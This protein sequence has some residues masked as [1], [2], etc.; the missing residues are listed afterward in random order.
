MLSQN[1]VDPS[2]FNTVAHTRNAVKGKQDVHGDLEMAHPCAM[3]LLTLQIGFVDCGT[4]QRDG[5]HNRWL[6]TVPRSITVSNAMSF[7]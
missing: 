4:F 5:F 3:A 1:A 2:R 6:R 7:V